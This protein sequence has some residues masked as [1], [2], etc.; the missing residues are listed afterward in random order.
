MCKELCIK[1][2]KKDVKVKIKGKWWAEWLIDA[3][4]LAIIYIG[5]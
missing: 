4:N 2:K 1:K 5:D 3:F